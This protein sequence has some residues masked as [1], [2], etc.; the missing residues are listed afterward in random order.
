MYPYIKIYSIL[1]PTYYLCGLIGFILT[2]IVVSQLLKKCN[3][4]SKLIK[5]YLFSFIGMAIGSRFVGI[6]SGLLYYYQLHKSINLNYAIHNSG[7]VFIG[8]LIGYIL[9][10]YAICKIKK[11]DFRIASNIAAIGI[12]LFHSFGRLGCYFS[13]CCYGIELNNILAVPY[14]SYYDSNLVN[15]LPVQLY[16][17]FFEFAL[18]ILL[19]CIYK[20]N[21]NN[22]KLLKLYFYLY[23][24]WRIIIEFFRGDVTRVVIHGIS[25]TQIIIVLTNIIIFIKERRKISYE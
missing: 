22:V 18:F 5:I 24:I 23:S 25:L 20:K 12:P 9:N 15:R 16:E 4:Y 10:L 11:I 14:K 21:K 17:S 13:G 3:F 1:F 19:F 2:F 8:G 6:I 7:I